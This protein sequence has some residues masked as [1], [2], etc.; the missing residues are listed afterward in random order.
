F[1][2]AQN[3]TAAI[4]LLVIR[5]LEGDFRLHRPHFGA[6]VTAALAGAGLQVGV[7]ES[8][9]LHPADYVSTVQND[10]VR[11]GVWAADMQAS[12]A[13]YVFLTTLIAQHLDANGVA[14]LYH[15]VRDATGW[16]I[17]YFAVDSRLFP[18]GVQN[19]GIFYAPVKLS[20]HRVLQL[21]D[22]RVLPVDFFQILG[23]TS[24]STTPVP[25]QDLPPSAQVQATTIQ[26]LPA[27]Y[28]SMFYRSYVGYSPTDL[29]QPNATGIPGFSQALTSFAP[30]PAGSTPLPGVRI[31]VTDELGTPHYLT[32]TDANG[33][34]SAVVPF[35]DI[36]IMASIGTATRTTLVGSRTLASTTLHVSLD[37]AM[38][39][40]ADLD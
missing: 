2:T 7:F 24:T 4:A 22:G 32:T 1:I 13:V 33:H 5:L 11:Y 3:E 23:T 16:D 9:F 31:T 18:I 40:P 35:G 26:Y 20:D 10:P 36:T 34:Y 14:S 8:V 39:S 15:A 25:I 38:R 6:G 30:V 29:G 37:Q 21:P 12:N 28:H 19:T 27:F 17:G